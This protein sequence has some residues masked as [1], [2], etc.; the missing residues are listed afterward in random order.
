MSNEM[1]IL[2]YVWIKSHII[3]ECYAYSEIISP[4][5]KVRRHGWKII[6]LAVKFN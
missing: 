6:V 2:F 5:Y 3:F 1:E 4:D